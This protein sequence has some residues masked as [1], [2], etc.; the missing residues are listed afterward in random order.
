MIGRR[1]LAG[2]RVRHRQRGAVARSAIVTA[3]GRH[4]AAARAGAETKTALTAAK[5]SV[6]TSAGR[7]MAMATTAGKGAVE[8]AAGRTGAVTKIARVS[9]AI[10]PVGRTGT[11]TAT[12]PRRAAVHAEGKSEMATAAAL[13]VRRT[14]TAIV[15]RLRVGT[16]TDP[17]RGFRRCQRGSLLISWIRRHEQS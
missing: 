5:D 12:A 1:G 10:P 7:R 3:A 6:V 16:A 4:R 11:A 2:R 9:V 15:S 14:G 13:A 17:A 8:L